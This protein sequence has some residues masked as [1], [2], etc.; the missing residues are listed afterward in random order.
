MHCFVLER[1]QFWFV[2]RL[3]APR[4]PNCFFWQTVPLCQTCMAVIFHHCPDAPQMD[5]HCHVRI[6]VWFCPFIPVQSFHQPKSACFRTE[7]KCWAPSKCL[8]A[9]VIE[10]SVTGCDM[11][12]VR[13]EHWASSQII[14]QYG[15]KFWQL[16]FQWS[17]QQKKVSFS[18]WTPEVHSHSWLALEVLHGKLNFCRPLSGGCPQTCF[19]NQNRLNTSTW[20]SRMQHGNLPVLFQFCGCLGLWHLMILISLWDPGWGLS[21]S[22][23]DSY[24]YD[25]GEVAFL[26]RVLAPF[27]S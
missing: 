19:L 2:S 13:V 7:K 3:V 16:E 14:P 27:L 17:C 23:C 11:W 24:M 4:L 8:S 22:N 26:L 1:V 20:S 21:R 12:I 25:V 10:I 18:E 9:K 5:I 6:L 15:P